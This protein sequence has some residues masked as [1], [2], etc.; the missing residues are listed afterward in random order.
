[1][2]SWVQL[3]CYLLTGSVDEEAR[4]HTRQN[5]PAPL[6][7]WTDERLPRDSSRNPPSGRVSW[8]SLLRLS[9]L[10]IRY[11][12]SENPAPPITEG[13]YIL[14]LQGVHFISSKWFRESF[15]WHRDRD[16]KNFH[17]TRCLRTVT[18]TSGSQLKERK[19][20]LCLFGSFSPLSSGLLLT[21][22]RNGVCHVVICSRHAFTLWPE[23][24]KRKRLGFCNFFWKPTPNLHISLEAPLFKGSQLYGVMDQSI[25]IFGCLLASS[26]QQLRN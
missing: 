20:F 6:Q 25:W 14:L 1:M 12:D 22:Y 7:Q 23:M 10:T 19:G 17:V 18:N 5:Q 24:K 16:I 15:K 26:L 3:P 11:F 4:T 21:A 8:E 9:L 13:E 2:V